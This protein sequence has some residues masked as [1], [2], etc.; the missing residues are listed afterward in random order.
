[1]SIKTL[2]P[3]VIGFGQF[4]HCWIRINE[5]NTAHVSDSRNSM[6]CSNYTYY[7]ITSCDSPMISEIL[8]LSVFFRILCK[9][10]PQVDW[11][12]VCLPLYGHAFPKMEENVYFASCT[13]LWL[14]T[15]CK[16]Y[17]TYTPRNYLSL[18]SFW[19]C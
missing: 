17:R 6:A 4:Y 19:S 5:T 15:P 16:S 10:R 7:D 12:H 18:K 8:T 14:P 13:S 2:S 9:S 3:T 11:R 1:M